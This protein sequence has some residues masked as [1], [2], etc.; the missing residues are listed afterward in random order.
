MWP[1]ETMD[2]WDDWCDDEHH[3]VPDGTH[4]AAEQGV[5]AESEH[6]YRKHLI[7]RGVHDAAMIWSAIGAL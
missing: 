1:M 2:D 7:V 5:P 6:S 4:P 3:H